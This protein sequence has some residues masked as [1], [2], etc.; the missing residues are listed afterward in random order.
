VG[1]SGVT[2]KASILHAAPAIDAA[3]GTREVVLRLATSADLLPGATVVVKLGDQTRRVVSVPREA[4][5]PEG[6]VLVTE[7]GRTSL[8]SVTVGGDVGGG[9]V[10]VLSGLS[11]GERV[12]KS[13]IVTR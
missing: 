10:E 8:R 11:S 6:F 9:R 7:N 4:V 3:S 13:A 2:A 1:L 5:S 12:A